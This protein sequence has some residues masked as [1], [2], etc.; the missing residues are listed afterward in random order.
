MLPHVKPGN[1]RAE[2]ETR[3][4]KCA[5]P[6]LKEVPRAVRSLLRREELFLSC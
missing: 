3:H 5:G 1:Y 2:I 6:T 4:K